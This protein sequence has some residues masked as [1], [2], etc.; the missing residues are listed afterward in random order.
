MLLVLGPEPRP[1]PGSR[2]LELALLDTLTLDR[3][4]GCSHPSPPYASA[5]PGEKMSGGPGA[6][7]GHAASLAD[8]EWRL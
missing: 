7:G 2:A 8:P 1:N 5:T 4:Q 6:A 3:S